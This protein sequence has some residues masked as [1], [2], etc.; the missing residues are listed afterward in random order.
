[1]RG[2]MAKATKLRAASSH[3]MKVRGLD[4]YFSPYE[5]IWPIIDLEDRMPLRMWEPCAGDGR[6]VRCLNQ[7]G[8]KTLASDIADYH[9]RDVPIQTGV[10]FLEVAELPKGV[11][12]I[13][14]NPPFKPA[15]RMVEKAVGMVPYSAWL[16]RL[17]FLESIDRLPFFRENPPA[18]IWI[19]S[20]RMPMM[21]RLGWDGPIAP[22]NVCYAWFIW[23]AGAEKT[24]QFDWFDW[25]DHWQ[26]LQGEY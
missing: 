2:E 4:A 14:T 20:R 12:G 5:G 8:F 7:H 21:H 9:V 13:I 11:G 15:M 1:M 3:S 26:D 6:I 22:S 10:D 24:K 16:L 25:K 18:R 19:S 17:Q 23:D